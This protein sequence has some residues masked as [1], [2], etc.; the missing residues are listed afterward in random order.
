MGEE[1][2]DEGRYGE[3]NR[4]EYEKKNLINE[5]QRKE[6]RETGTEKEEER[7]IKDIKKGRMGEGEADGEV[8]RRRKRRK[9]KEEEEE[10]RR[11]KK[12]KNGGRRRRK[13]KEE[14]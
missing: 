2:L 7:R 4:K 3:G 8:G 6:R 1:D 13:E 11:R 9:E 10:R 12:K 5:R 14:G